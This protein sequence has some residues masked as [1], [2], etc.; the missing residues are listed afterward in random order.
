MEG[1]I[2]LYRQ[3]A[4]SS[5][6][7]SEPFTRGQA[8][9]D[10]LMLANHADGYVRKRGVRLEVKRGQVGWSEVALCD[11]WR[12]GRGKV[13]RFLKELENDQQIEHQKTNITTIISIVNYEL[14]QI[15]DTANDTAGDT[16]DGH[17]IVQQ[18]DTK[19]TQTKRNKNEEKEQ[20]EDNLVST[21][22]PTST[23]GTPEK[24][25]L[26]QT[27][28]GQKK[29][30]PAYAKF[31]EW[32]VENAPMVLKLEQPITEKQFDILREKYK[33]TEVARTLL[34]MNAWKPLL[35]KSTNAYGTCYTWLNR[36][37]KK[38]MDVLS[39]KIKSDVVHISPNRQPENLDNSLPVNNLKET[40]RQ[41]YYRGND[42]DKMEVGLMD[43][44]D[45]Y[46]KYPYMK[47]TVNA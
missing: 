9:V 39:G 18:T 28:E 29:L 12:W 1:W 16:A 32:L 15:D 45:F 40:A 20:E 22:F 47:Q 36:D 24:D 34:A 27:N 43:E 42:Q 7:L 5:L 10:L 17:Q 3:L 11:R 41:Q 46:G 35:K 6:W 13:I 8:W 44:A 30:S 37:A 21:S 2:R 31:Q 4:S 23:V 26:P 38:G 14:Y 19:R 33:S 25:S